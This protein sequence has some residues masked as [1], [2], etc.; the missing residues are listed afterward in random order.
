MTATEMIERYDICLHGA[1]KIAV[2]NLQ[3]ATKDDAIDQ[4]KAAKAEIMAI[5]KA[6]V[7]AKEKAHAERQAKINAIEG[8]EELEYTIRAWE[9][10]HEAFNRAME[11]GDGFFPAMPSVKVEEVSNKYPR[12]AAY[13]T[14]RGWSRSANYAKASAGAKALEAI[15]NGEDH[16]QAV[17][18]MN[19][20]WTAYC[21]ERIWD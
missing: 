13:I 10:Y 20:E 15:I 9:D 11:E 3:K 5:L 12:A 4:I 19:A 21:N 18:A 6:E 1:D 16:E 7:E 2:R 17:K 14:A 8:L